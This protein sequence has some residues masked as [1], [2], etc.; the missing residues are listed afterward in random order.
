MPKTPETLTSCPKCGTSGFTPRGLKAHVCKGINRDSKALVPAT[1]VAVEVVDESADPTD[2]LLGKQL[3]EQYHRA[4]GGMREVLK[5]GAMMIVL[6]ETLSARE[7]GSGNGRKGDG[8]K[9]WIAEHA[10]EINRTTAYRFL[11]VAEVVQSEFELPA[12]V[13][14]LQL[15]TSA[16]EELPKK[17]QK[18]QLELWD[19][20]SGTSQRSWL[21]RFVPAKPRGGDHGGN[22]QPMT[23]EQQMAALK[24]LA[25]DQFK[26][27]LVDLH[28]FYIERR[29]E[30]H[31]LVSETDR[32]L[33]AELLRQIDRENAK[34]NR[35][36]AA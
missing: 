19:F 6:R 7:Q 27:L 28:E 14:F 16:P 32:Q 8:V 18:K 11:H 17:L 21:D 35:Q 25:D 22:P 12:K 34:S 1:P 29:C 13:S 10:P 15:A 33:L 23:P 24:L 36:L 2:A 4:T 30:R 26:R 5:F 31:D 20:V 3:T 9:A